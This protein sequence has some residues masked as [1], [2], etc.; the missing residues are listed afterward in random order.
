MQ[1]Q[2]HL[3]TVIL[4]TNYYLAPW[5]LLFM[6]LQLLTLFT[7]KQMR[8]RVDQKGTRVG[9]NAI[10]LKSQAVKLKS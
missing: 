8:I 10:T 2:I 6:A 4:V 7:L 5:N 3:Q 1:M 9:G